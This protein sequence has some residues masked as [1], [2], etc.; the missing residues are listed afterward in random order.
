MSLLQRGSFTLHSGQQSWFKIDCDAL[1][2]EDIEVVAAII[3]EWWP[4]QFHFVQGI[5]RGGLRLMRALGKYCATVPLG[6]DPLTL[7]V[8]DVLTTGGSMEAARKE[9][10]GRSPQGV[11]IFARIKPPHWI[12]P[13][14]QLYAPHEP[15]SVLRTWAEHRKEA[16]LP[17]L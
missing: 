11:V 5:P 12:R 2:D 10:R 13:V 9:I 1:S 15:G 7:I 16:G 3:A 14:F 17:P 8:D 6:D 4:Q